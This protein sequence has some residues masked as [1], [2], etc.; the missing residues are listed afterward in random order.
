MFRTVGVLL[1]GALTA[2]ALVA[3]G[4]YLAAYVIPGRLDP[5]FYFVFKAFIGAG[6]GLMVGSLQKV[7]PAPWRCFASFRSF[8]CKLLVALTRLRADLVLSCSCSA[9]V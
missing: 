2:T 7:K 8:L 5:Y 4:V 9:R 6:I 3:L 1:A